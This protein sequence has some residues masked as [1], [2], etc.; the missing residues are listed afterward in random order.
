MLAIQVGDPVMYTQQIVS[1]QDGS[2]LEMSDIWINARNFRV[3]AIVKRDRD[4]QS[5]S[6]IGSAPEYVRTEINL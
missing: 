6:I 4:G 2:P 3:S 1:L 5:L